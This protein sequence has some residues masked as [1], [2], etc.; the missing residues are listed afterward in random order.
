MEF[1]N[2][3]PHAINILPAPAPSALG[4][5]ESSDE[6]GMTLEQT[7]PSEGIARVS[8]TETPLHRTYGGVV[9]VRQEFGNVT[10][11]PDAEEG[12]LLIVSTIVKSA[13]PDRRDLVSPAS[14]VR[15]DEG[16]I[17]G[18]RSLSL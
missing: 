13:L 7:F 11:L 18:C 9:L 17:I 12:F 15:D 3:T 2:Y 10:G 14:L 1:K 16:R 6:D 8:V 4:R 5:N